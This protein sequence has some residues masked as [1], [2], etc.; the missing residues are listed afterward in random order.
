MA[1]QVQ[2]KLVGDDKAF[3]KTLEKLRNRFKQLKTESTKAQKSVK[4]Q[5]AKSKTELVQQRNAVRL[6]STAFTRLGRVG[7]ASQKLMQGQIRRTSALLRQQLALLKKARVLPQGSGGAARRAAPFVQPDARTRRTP[8]SDQSQFASGKILPTRAFDETTLRKDV[9]KQGNLNQRALL[10]EQINLQKQQEQATKRVAAE[11]KKQATAQEAAAKRKAAADQRAIA[12]E[13]R[14]AASTRKSTSA[15]RKQSQPLTLLVAKFALMA[16]AVQTLANILNST[17]GAALRNIDEFQVAAIGTAAAVTGIADVSQDAIGDAFNQNLDAALA[18]FEQLELV[19]ARFFATGQELQLAFN[20]L[21]QRGVVI[22][23]EEFEILG[24]VTDQIKLLTGGQ[25]TQIQ[26]QQEIR[27]ILDGNVRTTTAFGKALQ[28]RGVDIA[29]LSREVRATGSLKPFEPFLNG[30]QAAGPAIRR[31]LSSV[32]ATFTSLASILNRR[33]FQD[34]FDG[35]VSQIT[36]VNNFIIDNLDLL[37]AMGK[38][39]RDDVA[40]ALKVVGALFNEIGGL[41]IRIATSDV[42]QL[43]LAIGLINKA[44]RLGPLGAVFAIASAFAVLTGDAGTFGK[45]INI[46]FN[47]VDLL[48]QELGKGFDFLVEKLDNLTRGFSVLFS[49][50]KQLIIDTANL[51]FVDSQIVS[52]TRQLDE[53]KAQERAFGE[54]K[55]PSERQLVLEGRLAERQTEAERLRSAIRGNATAQGIEDS[56]D[57]ELPGTQRL[58]NFIDETDKLLSDLNKNTE[59]QAKTFTEK[60]TELFNTLKNRAL[61]RIEGTGGGGGFSDTVQP[62]DIDFRIDDAELKRARDKEDEQIQSRIAAEKAAEQEQL[63]NL[64]K[65]AESRLGVGRDVFEEENRLRQQALDNE[66]VRLQAAAELEKARAKEDIANLNARNKTTNNVVGESALEP[67]QVQL[68]VIERVAEREREIEQ[69]NRQIANLKAQGGRDAIKAE[70][71]LLAA[72]K[73]TNA[74]LI[75]RNQQIAAFGGETNAERAKR[76]NEQSAQRQ[77]QFNERNTDVGERDAFA[78]QEVT[79]RLQ[80]AVKTQIDAVTGAIDAAF[81]TIIDGFV[82]GSFEFRELT[83]TLAKD[84]IAAGFE[85]IINEIKSTVTDALTDMFQAI[86]DSAEDATAGAQRAAQG[87]LLGLGLLFAVLSRVGSD[88]EFNATGGGGSG[89]D[90]SSVQTRGLIGGDQQIAIAEINNGLQEALIPTNAILSAIEVNT[91]GLQGLTLGIDPNELAQAITAQVQGIF[92]QA[93]LQTP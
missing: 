47:G 43:I 31:T 3:L 62:R 56:I 85:G 33:I 16:F 70:T 46:A 2:V 88:G 84:F 35:V 6:L 50:D 63:A 72:T 52:I 57:D 36:T 17:F 61:G 41:I 18:T 30:L 21:A 27:A 19:A 42:G 89:V 92:S 38:V 44:L 59:G 4:Q 65:F 14:K 34:T 82:E 80:Q 91:R 66:I 83:Q 15:I 12:A 68:G 45:V 54:N 75:K 64:Q 48:F 51:T 77:L 25:N 74:E 23:E 40:S 87:L 86:G 10:R 76:I 22:R 73:E 58:K 53:L 60:I 55:P 67:L 93:L 7:V 71:D 9:N 39:L 78:Q 24:K 8:V 28:A 20:T 79:I 90:Q 37:V 1:D 29:Q 69:I 5:A 13:K 32:T 26:I 81:R 11:Q 49:G